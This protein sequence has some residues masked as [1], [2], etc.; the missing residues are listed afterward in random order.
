MRI[1]S[2]IK[3]RFFPCEK[4]RRDIDARAAKVFD[5]QRVSHYNKMKAL[6]DV[7]CSVR[8]CLDKPA[9][10]VRRKRVKG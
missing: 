9:P 1:L 10:S 6:N 4:V 2:R 8:E 3:A 5:D 7:V